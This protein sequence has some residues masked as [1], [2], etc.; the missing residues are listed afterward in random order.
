VV[1]G[2]N[3]DSLF[4][5][6][7]RAIGQPAMADDPRFANNA[8]R[9]RHEQEIDTAIGAWTRAH[10]SNDV[11]RTLNEASVPGGPIYSVADMFVDPHFNAR[12][13]FEEVNVD[14]GALKVP[15]ILPKLVSTPGSTRSAGPKLGEHTDE[16]L[17]DVL[18]LSPEA[19]ARL[20]TC[21]AIV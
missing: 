2:A 1:I 20:K 21:G 9:V 3:G 6:L 19:I 13:L 11:L 8:G 17:S 15:A 12:G 16:V 10:T 14:D 18:Q 4:K 5:R 7:M